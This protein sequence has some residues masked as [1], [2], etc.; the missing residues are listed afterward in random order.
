MT[1]R[2]HFQLNK[3]GSTLIHNRKIIYALLTDSSLDINA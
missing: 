1:P 3:H 2:E